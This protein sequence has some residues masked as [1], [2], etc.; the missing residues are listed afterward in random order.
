[1]QWLRCVSDHIAYTQD[2]YD[3]HFVESIYELPLV[4]VNQVMSAG[5]EHE[6]AQVQYSTNKEYESMAK[7]LKLMSDLRVIYLILL[8]LQQSSPPI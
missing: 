8:L 3:K 2:T 4:T 7:K 1:M 6:A 5:L